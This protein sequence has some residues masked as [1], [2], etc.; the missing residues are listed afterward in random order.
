MPGGPLAGAELAPSGVVVKR[1]EDLPPPVARM[2]LSILR[3]AASGQMSELRYVLER[4][5]LTPLIDG[6]FVADPVKMWRDASP[7]KSGRDALARFVELLSLPPARLNGG[8]SGKGRRKRGGGKGKK[9]VTL[10]IWPYFAATPLDRL[11]PSE[12]VALYPPGP[13][14][15]GGAHAENGPLQLLRP[16]HRRR[17]HLAR[18]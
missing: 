6:R 10:F 18:F 7:D 17:R 3:A 15:S 1:A 12:Q 11:S 14:A 13:G 4:N 8:A 16:D 5:E 2:R 9:R